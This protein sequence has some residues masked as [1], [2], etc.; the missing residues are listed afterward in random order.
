[1]FTKKVVT[2]QTEGLPQWTVGRQ[3]TLGFCKDTHACKGLFSEAS[4]ML[5]PKKS[6]VC[7]SDSSTFTEAPPY[8]KSIL[9]LILADIKTLPSCYII[10]W[11]AKCFTQAACNISSVLAIEIIHI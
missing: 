2:H 10:G 8:L 11:A 1:V 9:L 5:P 3:Q 4:T 6:S 7:I